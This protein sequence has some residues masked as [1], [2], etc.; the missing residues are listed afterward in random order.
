MIRHT[1]ANHRHIHPDRFWWQLGTALLV[2]A[3][4]A[5]T[6]VNH[7]DAQDVLRAFRSS[8]DPTSQ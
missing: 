2:G 4:E 5:G 1:Q 3:Q 6:Q 8:A 7:P